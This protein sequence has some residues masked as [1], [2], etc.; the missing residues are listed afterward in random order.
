MHDEPNDL[1]RAV[2]RAPSSCATLQRRR[3]GM[4]RQARLACLD[5]AHGQIGRQ[6]FQGAPP[7]SGLK[8]VRYH[9]HVR[10]GFMEDALRNALEQP[11]CAPGR[12]MLAH[13]NQVGPCLLYT[14]DAADE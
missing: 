8:A 10:A 4:A 2:R 12:G 9:Q 14:S 3:V 1:G 6:A 13:H 5:T 11:V 7:G